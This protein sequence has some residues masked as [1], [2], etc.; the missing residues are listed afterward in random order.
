MVEI[1]IPD[2]KVIGKLIT[3]P[4]FEIKFY[5]KEF[6]DWLLFKF[7]IEIKS[8]LIQGTWRNIVYVETV[9]DT[10]NILKQD[11]ATEIIEKAKRF[12]IEHWWE[13]DKLSNKL[14][15]DNGCNVT[16]ELL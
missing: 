7:M 6:K 13:F 3:G 4:K 12:V 8:E 15:I 2:L 11:E 1:L 14:F 10:E 5:S 16:K 9:L